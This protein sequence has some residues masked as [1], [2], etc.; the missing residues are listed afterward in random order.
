MDEIKETINEIAKGIEEAPAKPEAS[1]EQPAAPAEG[2]PE[3]QPEAEPEGQ[4]SD[5]DKAVA[6]LS[7]FLGKEL[8]DAE[9]IE[10]LAKSHLNSEAKVQD[11]ANQVKDL[12]QY[13]TWLAQAQANPNWELAMKVLTGEK[14]PVHQESEEMEDELPPAVSKKM[15]EIEAKLQAYE[16]EKKKLTLGE[17]QKA[18]AA[19]RVEIDKFAEQEG[20][21]D[22]KAELTDY[23]AKAAINPYVQ[24]PEKL[25]QWGRLVDNGIP[26]DIA[27][28]S[29]NPDRLTTK[30]KKKIA[31]D[32]HNK[33][34]VPAPKNAAGA[35]V[36]LDDM[37]DIREIVA[38][39]AKSIKN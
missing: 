17:S 39:L 21:E 11:L 16:E 2:Q 8:S 36:A 38:E 35:G 26:K 19:A 5:V 10:E 31:V 12:V 20:N 4:G 37:T 3:A 34:Q 14:L 9:A 33:P 30:I 28:N 24:M 25:A 6:S 29:L 27:W 32:Q 23:R 18:T 13:R 15:A 7:K 22:F 1:E